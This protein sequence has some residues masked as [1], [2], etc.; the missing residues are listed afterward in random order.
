[1]FSDKKTF[2][3]NSDLSLSQLLAWSKQFPFI[4]FL[5]SNKEVQLFADPYH[6][7]DWVL[8]VAKEKIQLKN[9]FDELDHML[10]KQPTWLFGY[11]GYDLKNQIENL[12]SGNTDTQ[13]SVDAFFFQPEYLI[14]KQNDRISI[15]G[16]NDEVEA[17]RIT[18]EICTSLVKP[19][20]KQNT[21]PLQARVSREAY[22]QNVDAI[23][24]HIQR[25]DI[26]EMNYCIEFFS[27]D[28]ATDPFSLYEKL[29]SISPMPFS[30][31]LRNENQFVICASPERYLAK[32]KNKIISQPIKG[33]ARRGSS[34]EEDE[35]IKRNLM[36]SEK[37]RAENVMIVDLVRN[38]LSIT[39]AKASVKVEELFG[40]QSY[41]Q[42]HQMVSTVVSEI[43]KGT[44]AIDVI[45]HSFPMGSMTGA[46]KISAM[47][48]IE[49]FEN[50]KRGIYSGA[51]GYFNPEGDFDF[52]VVIRSI[53]YN[54]QTKTISFNVGSAIT[55]NADAAAEYE[56]CL[57]KASAMM[58]ILR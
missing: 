35:L 37:E 22:I 16:C 55:I 46:P 25:G 56:E 47:E 38:D 42:L 30:A 40:I 7:Y 23:K 19:A 13:Q 9:V 4:T 50:S 3:L 24:K 44:S 32:R 28:F 45:K 53:F 48:I 49:E 57:L 52:N 43:R 36:E 21:P 39:A 58:Q 6:Q 1:M 41:R 18:Q 2:F 12:S 51:I 11:F 26:Y 27:N 15:L 34:T 54:Q 29:N 33:T 31:F 8:A 17:E 14:Y 20:E 5:N 10:S